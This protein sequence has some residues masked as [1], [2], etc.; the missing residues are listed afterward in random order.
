LRRRVW[1]AGAVAR[2]SPHIL[3]IEDHGHLD[4]GRL[5]VVTERLEEAPLADLLREEGA[6]PLARAL[7]LA[8]QIGEGLDAAHR[9][10]LVHGRLDGAWVM[11]SDPPE[12]IVL[13]GWEGELGPRP[14][15]TDA[16]VADAWPTAPRKQRDL[17]AF[18]A[19]L[20]EMLTGVAPFGD[21][22]PDRRR[23]RALRTL[24]R[25]VP[26]RLAGLVMR[27]LDRSGARR[28]P[29]LGSLLN[30]LGLELIRLESRNAPSARTHRWRIAAGIALAMAVALAA[31]TWRTAGV[32]R[33]RP[34]TEPSTA[35]RSMPQPSAPDRMIRPVGPRAPSAEPDTPVQPKAVPVPPRVVERPSPPPP[36]PAVRAVAP[37]PV[38]PQPPRPAGS[39]G[40]A[41]PAQAATPAG[42]GER[43]VEP[44]PAAII[45]WLL[46]GR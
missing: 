35:E 24:R 16:A 34:A 14:V 5:F 38:R 1:L 37:P 20:Y 23:P 25:E 31:L 10:G 21:G 9:M 7:T 29:D 15:A 3:A 44:D 45:D 13:T 40:A 46:R 36:L 39:A 28:R 12:R 41:R 26:W 18:A 43:D 22:E 33:F 2:I 11:V 42:S 4:D 27:A 30:A 32:G 8:V 19:L 6:L 17:V